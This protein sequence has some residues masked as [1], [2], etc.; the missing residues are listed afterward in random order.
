M[1]YIQKLSWYKLLLL[2]PIFL[3]GS[4][5]PAR[6]VM[7]APIKEEGAEFLFAKLKEKEL[8]PGGPAL[9]ITV[10]GI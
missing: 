6:K 9:P 10:S 3:F 1:V 5:S 2:A 4:C 8:K 7:K